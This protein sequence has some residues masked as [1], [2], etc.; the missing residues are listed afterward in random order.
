MSLVEKKYLGSSF[1][2]LF[3]LIY[4]PLLG[5]ITD[6]SLLFP[7]IFVV[8]NFVKLKIWRF[9]KNEILFGGGLLF[10]FMFQIVS[11]IVNTSFEPSV[12][13]SP[14]RQFLI[15]FCSLA[16]IKKNNI[17]VSELLLSLLYICLCNSFLIFYQFYTHINIGVYEWLYN[18]LFPS[19]MI[20]VV[21]KPGYFTG[22]PVAGFFAN[23][24]CIISFYFLSTTKKNK[25]FICA[26]VFL[27]TSFLTARTSL[28][29]AFIIFILNIG[30][31]GIKK[32][33][34]WSLFIL[35]IFITLSSSI[36]SLFDLFAGSINKASVIFELF[37]TGHGDH[38]TNDLFNNHYIMP[39]DIQTLLI[40]NA[41]DPQKYTDVGYIQQFYMGGGILFLLVVVFYF[42]STYFVLAAAIKNKKMFYSLCLFIL[43]FYFYNFK[44]PYLLSRSIGDIYIV[45]LSL[46]LV[47]NNELNKKKYLI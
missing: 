20:N 46:F 40:G 43:C 35:L 27:I 5:G 28:L 9:S 19:E 33:A 39:S 32:G 3:G 26:I 38:S 44:G 22:Y 8:L 25:Y 31:I 21:R 6:L 13:L 10:I 12:F 41:E 34:V 7:L 18:P 30:T 15:L 1:V 14:F 17:R 16:F 4:F 2:F 42:L 36:N 24:G 23:I 45:L 29:F 37:F 11:A 47:S